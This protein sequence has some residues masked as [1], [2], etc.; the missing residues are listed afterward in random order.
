MP[1]STTGTVHCQRLCSSATHRMRPAWLFTRRLLYSCVDELSHTSPSRLR[2]RGDGVQ[3]AAVVES[4]FRRVAAARGLLTTQTTTASRGSQS[5]TMANKRSGCGWLTA[6]VIG[7]AFAQIEPAASIRQNARLIMR[8][9][10]PMSRTRMDDLCAAA[11]LGSPSFSR[12]YSAIRIRVMPLP[13]SRSVF[14]RARGLSRNSR[15]SA[16]QSQFTW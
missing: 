7:F 13:M 4:V 1:K 14:G 3:L 5:M 2:A 6:T 8:H 11:P 16:R 15:R 9:P 12:A 10:R